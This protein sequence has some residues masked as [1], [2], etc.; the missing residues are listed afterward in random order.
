MVP[1]INGEKLELVYRLADILVQLHRR[2][3]L[4]S[5]LENRGTKHVTDTIV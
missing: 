2:L 4:T 3:L 1:D 5:F